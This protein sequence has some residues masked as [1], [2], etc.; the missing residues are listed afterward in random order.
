MQCWNLMA[1]SGRKD[2]VFPVEMRDRRGDQTAVPMQKSDPRGASGWGRA[3]D[4]ATLG[5]QSLGAIWLRA[6]KDLLQLH[7]LLQVWNPIQ[8]R[9]TQP[10]LSRGP[11]EYQAECFLQHFGKHAWR[12]DIFSAKAPGLVCCNDWS[13]PFWGLCFGMRKLTSGIT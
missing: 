1:G 13:T 7:R 5:D 8:S 9:T 11:W 10:K 2:F 3:G 12:N 4:V 6:R